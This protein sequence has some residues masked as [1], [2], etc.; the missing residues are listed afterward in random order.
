[1][2][3]VLAL[4][5]ANVALAASVEENTRLALPPGSASVDGRVGFDFLHTSGSRPHG[6]GLTLLRAETIRVGAKSVVGEKQLSGVLSSRD[7][8][9][10][11]Q[12][13]L[14]LGLLDFRKRSSAFSDQ[15]DIF[16]SAP[17]ISL[18]AR[19]GN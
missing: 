1:M 11:G 13:R 8:M 18:E 19:F 9:K 5:S 17:G 16:G 6:L 7:A 4:A 3:G 2:I 15:P 14:Q 10:F 12:V